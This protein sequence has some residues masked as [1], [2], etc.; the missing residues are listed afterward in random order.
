MPANDFDSV[1]RNA[2]TVCCLRWKRCTLCRVSCL[3]P[4]VCRQ[5]VVLNV[6]AS[7]KCVCVWAVC[8]RLCT[9]YNRS[10]IVVFLF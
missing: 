8:L 1:L 7:G 10:H 5:T 2:S 4:A 6:F 9:V 3:R